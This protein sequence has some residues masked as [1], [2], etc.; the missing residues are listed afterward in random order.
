MQTNY[1]HHK[2][3]A[4]PLAL[5][6]CVLGTASASTADGGERRPREEVV[7]SQATSKAVFPLDE[8]RLS[9][10]QTTL[11]IHLVREENPDRAESSVSVSLVD[12]KGQDSRVEPVGALGKYPAGEV[13]GKYAFDIGPALKQIRAAGV[14]GD[15]CMKLELKPLR[16]AAKWNRLRV[17]VSRPEWQQPPQK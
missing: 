14:S 9:Q 2:W 5:A 17:T 3:G 6:V 16:A 12:C 7:L 11:V 4:I 15:V 13:Q 8:G 10:G 1:R